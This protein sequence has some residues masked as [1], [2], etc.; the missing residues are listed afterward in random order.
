MSALRLI[1]AAPLALSLAACAA[2]GPDYAP[3]VADLPAEY[4]DA[5]GGG[6]DAGPDAGAAAWWRAFGDARLDALIDRGLAQNLS[7]ET[8]L[9]R[10]KEARAALRATGLNAQLSGSLGADLGW[11]GSFAPI[12]DVTRSE[13]ASLG[14]GFVLDLFGGQARSREQARAAL[15]AAELSVGTARLALISD[16][17]SAY[18]DARYNQEAA[19]IT[20][21]NIR[22]RAGTLALT[23]RQRAAGTGTDLDVAQARALL[24]ETKATLPSYEIGFHNAV[25]A[26]ATLLDAP[27][28]P[29][30]RDLQKGAPQPRPKGG[31]AAQA[32][33]P[34]DLLRN[35]PDIAAA[36]RDYAAAVAAIGVAEAALLPSITLSGD[37]TLGDLASWSFGPALS[38]PIF[39][40]PTLEAQTDQAIAAARQAE[41]TWRAAVRGAVEEVQIAQ[42]GLIRGARQAAA[43]RKAADS[44]D[45]VATLSRRT[46]EGG[47]TTL[48]DLL[49]AER[50]RGAARLALAAAIRDLSADWAAL[51]IAA[52]RGW[53]RAA[54]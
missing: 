31:W 11:S 54:D 28:A 6:A 46:W 17:V 3:P 33:A 20:R 42:T 30:V 39:N 52:G 15:G 41:L 38:L 40:R 24:D 53:R 36:E 19:E 25:Y 21:A 2:V 51:Q 43:L 47:R 16:L 29:L 32:G 34:A 1:L 12:A 18:L 4:A 49:D 50:S 37:V 7:V 44:Y 10:V 35:R 23:E 8:A 27:A 48:L 9:A 45:R 5:P 26:I 13:S 14:A 22:L